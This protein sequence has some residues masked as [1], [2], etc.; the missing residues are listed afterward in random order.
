MGTVFDPVA[1]D[2]LALEHPTALSSGRDMAIRARTASRALQAL[3]TSE[4]VAMLNRIADA[5]LA[6]QDEILAANEKDMEE[7]QARV[8]LRAH[9]GDFPFLPDDIGQSDSICSIFGLCTDVETRSSPCILL[10]FPFYLPHLYSL[11]FN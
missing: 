11:F 6:R 4:R 7:A 3:P 1:L 8:V 5:L 9:R 10:S 2:Q